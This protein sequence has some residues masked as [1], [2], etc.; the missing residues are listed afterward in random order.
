[1]LLLE[2]ALNQRPRGIGQLREQ[3][4]PNANHIGH[5]KAQTVPAETRA[6]DRKNFDHAPPPAKLG[7]PQCAKRSRIGRAPLTHYGEEIEAQLTGTELNR[8]VHGDRD[9]RE[10]RAP[11]LQLPNPR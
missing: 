2:R 8:I 11:K 10:R 4:L 9:S 5:D 7:Q 3:T 1:L 6:G